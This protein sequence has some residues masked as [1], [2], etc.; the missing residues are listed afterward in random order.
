MDFL[1]EV[2]FYLLVCIK[3]L[4]FVAVLD[5]FIYHNV[6]FCISRIFKFLLLATLIIIQVLI[7]LD[8]PVTDTVTSFNLI[9]V[10]F[11]DVELVE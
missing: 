6:I 8:C 11:A 4:C 5:F 1:I 2:R 9:L 10:F 3:N 7:E